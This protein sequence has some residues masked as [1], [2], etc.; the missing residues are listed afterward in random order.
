MRLQVLFKSSILVGLLVPWWERG[1]PT[2]CH[3]VRVEA[4]GPAGAPLLPWW[5][6][7]L[8]YCWAAGSEA[9]RGLHG[10]TQLARGLLTHGSGSPSFHVPLC[11]EWSMPFGGA[12]L[13]LSKVFCLTRLLLFL[14][15]VLWLLSKVFGVW[16]QVMASLAPSPGFTNWEENSEH[17]SHVFLGFQGP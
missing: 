1:G 15:F 7:T 8:H 12:G 4:Q 6:Y 5:V 2:L 16:L 17:S 13:L 11:G 3:L 10:H 14:F 9:P